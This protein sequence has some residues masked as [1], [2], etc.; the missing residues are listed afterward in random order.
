MIKCLYRD[1]L[2]VAVIV[3]VPVYTYFSYNQIPYFTIIL[4][5]S[6]LLNVY[7]NRL[8]LDVQRRM[9]LRHK[10][11]AYALRFAHESY[12]SVFVANRCQRT[13]NV[14]DDTVRAIL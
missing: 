13:L 5:M 4:L 3:I 14:I 2:L 11:V 1:L 10:Q 12:T 6:A 7:R 8:F 9:A